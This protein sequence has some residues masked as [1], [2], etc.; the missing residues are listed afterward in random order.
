VPRIFD[1]SWG[2]FIRR[3]EFAKRIPSMTDALAALQTQTEVPTQETGP[4]PRLGDRDRRRAQAA[5]ASP[6][7]GRYLAVEDGGEIILF[8]LGERDGQRL[9]IGRSPASDILLEDP[10]VSRR[11]AVVVHRDGR[12][13]LLDDRSLNGIF[14]NG[15]RVGEA[16]LTDGDAIVIGHVSLRY[17]EVTGG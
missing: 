17:V 10:S 8:A 15:E 5:M 6:A 9:R 7:P 12:A 1:S 13:V 4:L 2:T 3:L 14:V 11:H 16:A